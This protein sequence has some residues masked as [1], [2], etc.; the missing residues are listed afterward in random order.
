MIPFLFILSSFFRRDWCKSQF[1]F[2]IIMDYKSKQWIHKREA[3][4]RRDK[5]QCQLSK[6]YGKI[7]QAEV[8]HH[9]FP[10]SQFPEY[11]WQDWN[12]ISITMD[13]HNKLHDR[14]TGQ[15]TDYGKKLMQR[16]ARKYGVNIG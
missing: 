3:I 4:L 14:V 2:Y 9:I 1:L 6:R 7:R 5:Y 16:T 15:L 11:Q 10:V 8:V 12:L 13:E